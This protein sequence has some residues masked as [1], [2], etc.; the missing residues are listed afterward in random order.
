MIRVLLKNSSVCFRPGVE[1]Q[2]DG[3]FQIQS[4]ANKDFQDL[5]LAAGSL[6]VWKKSRTLHVLISRVTLAPVPA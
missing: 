2:G 3:G 4:L 1:G 6:C 5:V